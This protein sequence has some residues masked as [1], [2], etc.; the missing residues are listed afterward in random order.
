MIT[1]KRAVSAA[2]L[3]SALLGHPV[4][5]T[6]AGSKDVTVEDAA[7]FVADAEKR[8][9]DIAEYAARIAWVNA[10]FVTHDTTM[11]NAQVGEEYTKLGVELANEAKKFNG[12][13]LPYDLNRKIEMIKLGLTLPAPSDPKKT[14]QLAEISSKLDSIYAKG[15]SPDGRSLGE[16]S[17]VLRESRDADEQLKAWTG[18]REISKEMRPLYQQ[19]VEIA[20]EGSKE[21]GYADT[22]TMWR[23]KYD[24]P[25]DGFANEMDRLWGQ[26]K[27][28]YTALHCHVRAELNEEYGD[29]VVSTDKPI[30][31][32]LLGNMWAQQ[33]G[34]IYDIAGPD[35]AGEGIDIDPILREHYGV[36]KDEVSHEEKEVAVK[37]MV[38]TA[39]NF[40]SSLG[41]APLPQTFW[42]RSLFVKPRDRDVQCHASAWDIDNEEDI[43]IKMCTEI[44]GED[45]QTV[46]HELG[47]NYYQ[48]AYKDQPILYKGS[49]NDGFHEAI[50]DTVALSITPKYLKQIGLIDEEPDASADIALLMRSA[51]DKVAFLPFGLMVDQWRWKVFNGEISP[52]E[53]N[54]GWWE[55]RQKYQG[56]DA[57]VARTEDHFDPGAK[58]HIPGNTPYSR[59]FLA[60]I[61]QFQFYREMCEMAGNE[62]PLHRC[63][64]YGNKEVGE[65]LIKM[66]EMGS[67]RPW[68]DAL[69]AMTGSREMDATAVLEYYAPLKT[70]LDEQNKGRNCGW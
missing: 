41:F 47:H 45:F 69:E 64:F 59:Y 7:A 11:L 67:S 6:A 42:E 50:G 62:G 9:T 55:L 24:M 21:L 33:W 65:K 23:S 10:N 46:H 14:K 30:P 29:E 15:K 5:S 39:E 61:L 54:Q 4:I 56:I 25:A 58:Y 3:T 49:A 68:P 43:R 52:E 28:L 31:A 32:H 38:K 53:Y 26:V 36:D 63:S 18:W 51:L 40:F 27:P 12:L 19:M 20:N 13:D 17:Q 1:L 48:R 44:N 37:K 35:S 34:N 2:I 16:L 66:L 8:L 70:W 22:G 57:P 60:H